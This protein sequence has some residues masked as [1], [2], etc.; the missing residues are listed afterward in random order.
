MTATALP[1]IRPATPA[2]LPAIQQLLR[3]TWHATYDP[4]YGADEVARVSCQWHALDALSRQMDLPQSAFLVAEQDGAI[5]AT[6]LAHEI[7]PGLIRLSRLYVHPAIQQNGLGKRLL[8][9]TLASFS[10]DVRVRLDVEALNTRAIAFYERHGFFLAGA[11]DDANARTGSGT[12]IYE[13]PV[14]T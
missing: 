2:D 5:I 10:L 12:L 7:E 6:S 9:A 8:D 14:K 3:E 11:L 13:R 4:I 1:H